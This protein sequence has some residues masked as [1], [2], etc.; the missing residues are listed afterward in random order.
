MNC[1]RTVVFIGLQKSG[2]S[3]E[4][5]RAAENLGYFIVVFMDK[6]R[7]PLQRDAFPDV[8]KMIF[9]DIKDEKAIQENIKLLEKH[10]LIIEAII[11]FVDACVHTA[12]VLSNQFCHTKM[13]TEAIGKMEDK[14]ATRQFLQ[15]TPF[16]IK[17]AIY[18]KG[19]SVDSFMKEHNLAYPVI[20]K[21]P[22]STGSKD[23]L[24]S[25]NKSDLINHVK[26]LQSKYPDTPILFEEYIEGTQYL[27]EVL[28]YN[29]DIHL[30]AVVEQEITLGKRFIVTG[31]SLLAQV[32]QDLYE[33]LS[34]VISDI[35][36]KLQFTNGSCHFELRRQNGQWKVI[37]INA[38]IAGGAMNKMV[39]A[40]YGMNLVEQIIQIWLGMEPSLKHNKNN[41]VFTQYL[42]VSK[43]GILKKVTGKKRA[44]QHK[45]VVDVYIKPKKGAR[46]HPPFSMGHRYAYVL[47]TGPTIEDAKGVA[48]AAAKE[49]AFHYE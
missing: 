33:S 37:E 8:H 5:I 21:Y 3:R 12:A 17:H 38:R 47:A 27:V 10:G 34:D 1:L 49:I 45:G 9:I 25:E 23:V 35:I 29:N 13:P 39:E 7:S 19:Q 4:A 15:H 20:L 26:Q 40:A 2:S 16:G 31:Y 11:S 32:P 42:T 46:L 22:N 30:V 24:K 48:I 18:D 6:K 36:E 44:L 43:N 41:F 28:V 14:I